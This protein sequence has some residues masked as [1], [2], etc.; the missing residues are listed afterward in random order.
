MQGLDG[1][2]F[3]GQLSTTMSNRNGSSKTRPLYS[4]RTSCCVVEG[5]RAQ[6]EFAQHTSLVDRFDQP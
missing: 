1:L 5:D 4:M 2:E 6:F 3:Q